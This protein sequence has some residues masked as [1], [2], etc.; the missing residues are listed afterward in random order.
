MLWKFLISSSKPIFFSL[1]NQFS[2]ASHGFATSYLN[3]QRENKRAW[4]KPWSVQKMDIT[5]IFPLECIS[6]IISFTSPRDACRSSLV[7]PT[8]N[9]ASNSNTVWERFLPP[10]YQD[11]IS[12]KVL[13]SSLNSLTKKDLY[14]HLCDHPILID[15]SNMVWKS[16][17]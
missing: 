3:Y 9:S 7:S 10:D 16:Q 17:Y 12:Q 8:F 4:K 11:I 1:T 5:K 6:H 14:F 15:N 2:R 13:S